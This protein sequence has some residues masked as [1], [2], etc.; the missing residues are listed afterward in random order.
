MIDVQTKLDQNLWDFISKR[1]DEAVFDFCAELTPKYPVCLDLQNC[2]TDMV[3]YLENAMILFSG[4][5]S[6]KF[7]PLAAAAKQ[8]IKQ[9]VAKGRWNS[10]PSDEKKAAD[11]I[12]QRCLEDIEETQSAVEN[13]ESVFMV[14]GLYSYATL[15]CCGKSDAWDFIRLFVYS[16]LIYYSEK[17]SIPAA[18]MNAGPQCVS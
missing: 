1:D 12:A 13:P 5:Q 10:M 7:G 4:Y 11:L 9:E 15:I 16:W 14:I 18:S 8:M 3:D 6:E 2:I 17:L